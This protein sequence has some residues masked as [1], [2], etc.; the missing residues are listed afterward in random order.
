MITAINRPGRSVQLNGLRHRV[1]ASPGKTRREIGEMSLDD[2]RRL[3]RE[4]QSRQ[5]ELQTEN[6][7]LQ[8]VQLEL[9]DS[10][11]QHA[12][13]NAFAPIGLLRLTIGGVI[14]EANHTAI[15]LMGIGREQMIS[16]KIA[17]FIDPESQ[18]SFRQ[19]RKQVL[20]TGVK[21]GCR[22]EMLRNNGSRFTADMDYVHVSNGRRDGGC[23]L[24]AFS[25]ITE[26]RRSEVAVAETS[27]FNLQIA[28]SAR[29]GIIVYGSDLRFQVWNPFMEQLTGFT[30]AEVVGKYP[31]EVFP[32]L[33]ETGIITQ[34]K[35]ALA[36][37][38]G[39]PVEY[40]FRM[41]RTGRSAW[42]SDTSAPLRNSKGEIVGVIGIVRDISERKVSDALLQESEEQFRQ[43]AENVDEVFWMLDAITLR[44]LYVSPAYEN[45][46]GRTCKSRYDRTQSWLDAVHPVD[47]KR[48]AEA[49][50]QS[51]RRKGFH[52]EYRIVLPDGSIRWIGDSGA[53]VCNEAGSVYRI[54]G[55]AR[56]ITL[57]R[58]AEERLK[59][60]EERYRYLVERA[61]IAIFIGSKNR[62][63]YLNPAALKL[64]G[65]RQP[66]QILGQPVTDFVHPDFQKIFAQQIASKTALASVQ[67]KFLRLDG[68]PL[69]VE[70]ASVSVQWGEHQG[71][72]V[73]VHDVTP[74]KRAEDALRKNEQELED[75]FTKSPL[76]L[77]WAGPDGRIV[78]INQ[79]ALKLFDR[80]LEVVLE[81]PISKFYL[82]TGIING[83]RHQLAEKK[84]VQN[85]RAR[86]RQ[87]NGGIKHVLIDA[88][89]LWEKGQLVHT[90]WFVRDITRRVELEKEILSISERE[91]RRLGQ[92]LHD[93]LC[94]QLAGIEFLTQTLR[95]ALAANSRPEAVQAREVAR[96]VRLAMH[97]TRE[98]AHGL[99]PVRLEDEGLMNALRELAG[100]IR[101]VF[102]IDCRFNCRKAVRVAEDTVSIHLYRIAQ[103]AI[104]N[105]IKHGKAR[106]VDIG[107]A[108]KDGGIVLK[109]SN[110]GVALPRRPSDRTGMGMHIMQYR[111]GIIGGSL[112]VQRDAKKKVTLV[113]TISK[114]QRQAAKTE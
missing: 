88:N 24:M 47:R 34:L 14:V 97:K 3:V 42:V 96:M 57:R 114:G 29:E 53:V 49:F 39:S 60:S 36:G 98:L 84:T 30:A 10:R 13:L 50:K 89:G 52:E 38:S 69:D 1:G 37:E 113:C 79:A 55:V 74:R 76:G 112:V 12:A 92:D 107:L 73:I 48:V 17:D 106:R 66:E 87:Q 61:P 103:E 45:I 23:C 35:K 83:I 95:S 91:Q 54:V 93:D 8:R 90:R 20:A 15:N 104:S 6:D 21:Q 25:D 81:R 101:T 63:A 82:D 77:F 56:D 28:A 44:T 65:A 67:E 75:F 94:Q 33:Q 108:A 41:P 2:T 19:L 5:T 68:T 9:E 110:N 62:F 105:A 80:R 16:K 32:F 7:R 58:R 100:R 43:M 99:S 71:E 22:L 70:V 27:Q 78:R 51:V 64:F 59:S 46:W 109:V 86:I 26:S 72:Q 102:Q 4:L 85:Y 40:F 18:G 111:A 11:D 31:E